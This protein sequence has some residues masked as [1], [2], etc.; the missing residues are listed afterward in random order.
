MLITCLRRWAIPLE[1]HPGSGTL[2]PARHKARLLTPRVPQAEH[3]PLIS[4][5]CG[6]F[7][8]AGWW[9][10]TATAGSLSGTLISGMISLSYPDYVPQRYQIFLIYIGI[11]LGMC[12]MHFQRHGVYLGDQV[13]D[14]STSSAR[15]GFRSSTRPQS[16]GRSLVLRPYVSSVWRVPLENTSLRHSSLPSTSMRRAGTAELRG[17]GAVQPAF[18][19]PKLITP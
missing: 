18:E 6:W 9:A 7:C 13:P 5:I 10:L 3:A 2:K 15:G 17:C 16:Y 14:S 11:T 19:L 8:T 4:W 12:Y 1:R